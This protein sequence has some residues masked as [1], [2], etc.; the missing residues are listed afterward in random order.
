MIYNIEQVKLFQ[1]LFM[2]NHNKDESSI[3]YVA[4]RK[5]YDQSL[6]K[7]IG[8]TNRTIITN[9]DIL[10]DIINSNFDKTYFTDNKEKINSNALAVY[11]S[12][13]PRNTR[14]AAANL[15]KHII[16]SLVETKKKIDYHLIPSKFRTIVQQTCTNKPFSVLD[17]DN[18]EYYNQILDIL[19]TYDIQPYAIIETHGGYH[20]VLH[21]KN[22]SNL[23]KNN[24]CD[25]EKNTRCEHIMSFGEYVHKIMLKWVDNN[26]PDKAVVEYHKDPYSPV[27]GTYQG[28]FPVKLIYPVTN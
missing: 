22:L 1:S 21:H 5:K 9:K 10:H 24:N 4:A 8:L 20:I 27:A 2:N 23:I 12:I 11:M 19:K 28:G 3:I 18:K 16:D 6:S 25:C 15:S 17:V 26:N 7:N 14:L 13:N